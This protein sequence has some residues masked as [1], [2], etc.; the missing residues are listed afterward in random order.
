MMKTSNK[1]KINRKIINNNHKNKNKNKLV[2][3]LI[4]KKK[5]FLQSKMI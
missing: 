4:I 1:I 5:I 2:M 3:F